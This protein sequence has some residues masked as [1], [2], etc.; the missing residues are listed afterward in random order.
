MRRILLVV[1]LAC[2]LPLV[3][4]EP[5]TIDGSNDDAFQKTVRE[6]REALPI[7]R[8][9]L[10]DTALLAIGF[11]DFALGDFFARAMSGAPTDLGRDLRQQLN[12]LN[13]L[14]VFALYDSVLV[15]AESKAR[16]QALQEITKLRVR[17]IA[18]EAAE[19][20]LARFEVRRSRFYKR[21]RDYL[22]TEPIIELT[23]HNGTRHAISRAYFRGRLTTPGRSVSW[24][25]EPFNYVV[26]GGVEPDETVSWTLS[27]N[28][29]GALG[30]ADAPSGAVFTV[31]VTRLDGVDGESLFDASF[32]E[33]DRERLDS[34]VREFGGYPQ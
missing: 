14:G 32:G 30:E 1:G 27:F 12:G 3:A 9:A 2:A 33:R 15:A 6:V 5:P 7:E 23:V 11:A 25:D 10:L 16:E 19:V 28:R 4:C 17:R 13:A 26:P 20:G 31:T 34:L 21:E 24:L 18:S 29:F 22:G 8:Q